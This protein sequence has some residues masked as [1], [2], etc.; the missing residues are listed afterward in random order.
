MSRRWGCFFAADSAAVGAWASAFPLP[1]FCCIAIA[2][3]CAL[4]RPMF[5]AARKPRATLTS[6]S[7]VSSTN[8]PLGSSQ[9]NLR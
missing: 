8:I 3:E 7:T 1:F 4:N 6:S 5:G 9:P 2:G